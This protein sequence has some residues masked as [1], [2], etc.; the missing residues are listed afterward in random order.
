M[1]NRKRLPQI[2]RSAPIT[3]F[4]SSGNFDKYKQTVDERFKRTGK[5]VERKPLTSFFAALLILLLAIL[6][7]STVFKTRVAE[8]SNTVNPKNVTVYALG[9]KPSVNVQGQVQK[10]GVVTI[11]AQTPGIVSE[12]HV[13]EGT[14]VNRKKTLIS[15]SSNYRGGNVFT[16][17]RQLA[18]ASYKNAKD[19][20]D[21]QMTL[22]QRQ[23]DLA[24][25]QSENAE[26]MRNL[27]RV[28]IDET[29]S[30]INLNA[31]LLR[32]IQTS[33][34]NAPAGSDISQLQQ[35]QAQLQAGQNQLQAGLRSSEYQVDETRPAVDLSRIGKDIA[36]TQLNL[37][38]KALKFSL[39]AAG[40]QLKLAQIQEANMYP[41]SPFEGVVQ[42]IHVK[43]GDSV[44][45]GTPLITI[46]GYEGEIIIDAK[47]PHDIARTISETQPATIEIDKEKI[48]AVPFYIS[49][50]A[51]SGQLYS[52]LFSLEDQ[53]RSKFTDKSFVAITLPIGAVEGPIP[54]IPV[55]S[56]FQ[57]QDE[58]YVFVESGGKAV[59]KKVVLGPVVGEYVTVESGLG[60][61]ERIILNRNVSDGDPV[62]IS[63]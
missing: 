36:L 29:R 54:F 45:P 42:K 47:V 55:D 32:S 17:Q 37:Q 1:A 59:S 24:N 27:T 58:A 63:H 12:I 18:G 48:E 30:L 60:S 15:L 23:R 14:E 5:F 16:V 51:T 34:Q 26:E 11:S 31:E 8:R 9:N 49:T 50:E 43:V 22:I 10:A 56:V 7:G 20:Y 40:L 3:R 46:S 52:V 38:E 39:Q 19:T 21:L 62:R 35:A 53:Y 28:S 13:K 25:R 41:T 44:N 6:L 61:G 2:K 57:T 4:F 33:I